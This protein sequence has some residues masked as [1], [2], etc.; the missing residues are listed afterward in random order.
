MVGKP[1]VLIV[2]DDSMLADIFSRALRN[3]DY[4]TRVIRDGLSASN[5]LKSNVP[6]LL[7]LDLHLPFLSGQDIL[8]QVNEDARFKET[9]VMIATADAAFARFLEGN[10]TMTLIKPIDVGQLQKLA[11]RLKPTRLID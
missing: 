9:K 11:D 8:K 4:D 10:I 1:F 7:V 5:W 3:I 2:E 6:N